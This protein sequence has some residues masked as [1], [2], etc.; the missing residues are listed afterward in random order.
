MDLYAPTDVPT[1]GLGGDI[2]EF[3]GTSASTPFVAG[4]AALYKNKKG[5]L[6]SAA[7]ERWL[8]K[9]STKR[10]LTGQLGDSPNQLL[11][12]GGL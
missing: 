10:V 7:L 5:D 6:P 8:I 1:T 9:K 3:S 2:V 11:Y 4:V 12:T